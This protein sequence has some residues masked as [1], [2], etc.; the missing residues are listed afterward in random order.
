M[1]RLLAVEPDLVVVAAARFS[2]RRIAAGR[3]GDASAKE[4]A[5]MGLRFNEAQTSIAI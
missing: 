2:C 4:Y 5:L 1:H 3:P